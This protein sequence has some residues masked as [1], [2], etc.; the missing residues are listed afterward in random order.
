LD[1]KQDALRTESIERKPGSDGTPV[2]VDRAVNRS[3]LLVLFS[4]NFGGSTISGHLT[5]EGF[6]KAGWDVTIAVGFE[7]VYSQRLTQDGYDVRIVPHRNWFRRGSVLQ[8]GSDVGRQ[9][10]AV[11]RFTSLI[12]TIRPAV[13]YVNSLASLPAVIAAKWAGV[14]CVLHIRELFG[15]VGGEMEY[16]SLG[17]RPLTHF[18]LRRFPDQV[19]VISEAVRENCLGGVDGIPAIVVPNA[20][21]DD[22][23]DYD[24]SVAD[25]RARLQLPATGTL[26]GVPGTLRPMKG[27]PFLLEVAK[28][29]VDARPEVRFLIAGDG[30]PAYRTKLTEQASHL[31]LNASVQ[32]LGTISDMRAFYRACDL[33]C[34]PSRAEPFGRIVIEAFTLGCPIVGTAVG[35]ICETIESGATGILANYGDVA[36]FA[37]ALVKLVD[38]PALRKELATKARV[39]AR[40]DYRSSIYQQRIINIVE[41]L[42]GKH[43]AGNL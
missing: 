8:W 28:R 23:F 21:A 12:H 36:G 33:V 32:F 29:V 42:V 35:G 3:V 39:K 2:T 11:A 15:D 25:C 16:P 22:Y 10:A 4:G 34:V 40:A 5:A 27:H 41:Q 6:R 9:F 19:V 18:L 26:I 31:G 24:E 43:C 14:P 38:S 1:E 17:G 7:G 37:E 20:V 30:T 13:V